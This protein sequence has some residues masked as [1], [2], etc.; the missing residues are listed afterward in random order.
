MTARLRLA[1]ALAQVGQLRRAAAPAES[2]LETDPPWC[3]VA[4]ARR[5]A[6]PGRRRMQAGG[7]VETRPR[8]QAAA[9]GGLT[10]AHGRTD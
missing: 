7:G 1:H 9:S 5:A 2:A 8:P 4:A 3:A 10:P 6:D